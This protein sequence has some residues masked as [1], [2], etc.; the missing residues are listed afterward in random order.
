MR[1]CGMMRVKNEARWI[2]ECVSSL[3]PVCQRVYVLDD[4]SD[5]GTFEILDAMPNVRVYPSPFD[6]LDEVRDKNYLLG[7]VRKAEWDWVVHIDGDEALY[8]EDAPL[9]LSAIHN[10][11]APALCMRVV[12]LWNDDHTIRVDRIYS[13]IW[14]PSAFRL[15]DN[16]R[17]ESTHPHGYH[18]GNAPAN[19]R[20]QS[21]H[22][23]VRLLHYG[24]MHQADRLRK[25]REY[26]QH[27]P[28]AHENDGYR[29]IVQGD[30]PEVPADAYLRYAGPLELQSLS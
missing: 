6:G 20:G 25:Y 2:R 5:D 15:T 22:V 10:T 12:Y 8:A 24:Y 18:C 16:G 4:H 11:H 1:I 14:R 17:F 9:L 7:F 30:V 28:E 13:N 27:D 19:L 26:T 29:H 3:F 23:P 21:V